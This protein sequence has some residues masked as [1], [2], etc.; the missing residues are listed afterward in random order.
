MSDKHSIIS[1]EFRAAPKTSP[2]IA[3]LLHCASTN[4]EE[5]AIE[6]IK[7]ILEKPLDWEYLYRLAARHGVL[8]LLYWNLYKRTFNK[9]LMECVPEDFEKKLQQGFDSILRNNLFLAGEL[10]RV[11]N[12]LKAHGIYAIPYKGP[13]LA[14]S[15]YGNLALRHFSDLDILVHKR[16]IIET[17]KILLQ[18][19]QKGKPINAFIETL[20]LSFGIRNQ[21][22]V[23]NNSVHLEVHWHIVDKYTRC[24]LNLESMWERTDSIDLFSSGIPNLSPEDL[25]LVLSVHGGKHFWRQLKWICDIS[26]LIKCFYGTIDWNWIFDQSIKIGIHRMLLIG[27]SLAKNLLGTKLPEDVLQR[28]EADKKAAKI[29]TLLSERLF[30]EETEEAFNRFKYYVIYLK[31]RE[32][33]LDKFRY[34]PYMIRGTITPSEEDRQIL[35]LPFYLSF[36]YI[37]LRPIRLIVK[38]AFI[39]LEHIRIRLLKSKS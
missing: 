37:L 5:K 20:K 38:Y 6:R 3:L 19:Y 32:C 11:L 14:A 15:V 2:E 1:S 22:D 25:I 23:F 10:V 33:L 34:F 31:M 8:P 30:N 28:L 21:F 18:E 16:D 26:E 27:L 7:K 39:L 35:P 29:G 24:K 17:K 9:E 4:L 36:I 13:V 12:L